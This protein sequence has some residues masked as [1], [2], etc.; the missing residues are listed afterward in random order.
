MADTRIQSIYASEL[1]IDSAYVDAS[2]SASRVDL[3]AALAAVSGD[4]AAAQAAADAAQAT[5]DAAVPKTDIVP[6][7]SPRMSLINTAT[8]AVFRMRAGFEGELYEAQFV[9]DGVTTAVGAASVAVEVDG[10]AA[11]T[12]DPLSAPALSAAGFALNTTF[13]APVAFTRYQTIS[14][15]VTTANTSATFGTVTLGARRV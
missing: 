6:I 4:A 14:F 5:A 3:T 2:G 7:Y 15:T 9:I 12:D 13:T 11:A 8:G 1:V 10:V